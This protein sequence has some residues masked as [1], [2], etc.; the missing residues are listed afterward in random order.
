MN[1]SRPSFLVVDGNNIIHAWPELLK[2]FTR[3]KAS[4]H[5]ELIK[6]LEAYQ[7]FSDDRVVVVFDGRGSKMTEEREPGSIQVIFS[8][9]NSSADSVIERLATGNAEKYEII[10][11]TDDIPVQD[12]VIAAGG[13]AIS[14]TALHERI[15]RSQGE[16]NRWLDARRKR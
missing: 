2:I 9:T 13:G 8:S 5:S 7:D 11:A 12:A 4:G 14:S 3:R 6:I 1:H 16:M 15:E 10:V